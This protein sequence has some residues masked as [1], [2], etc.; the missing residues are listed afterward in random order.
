MR[1]ILNLTIQFF[2]GVVISTLEILISDFFYLQ[3]LRN[4]PSTE[5][6]KQTTKPKQ[7]NKTKTTQNKTSKTQTCFVQTEKHPDFQTSNTQ[8]RR[9]R[10]AEYSA[11]NNQSKFWKKFLYFE[12]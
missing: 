8:G 11:S 6:D 5:A 4:V 12:G 2:N 9:G 3:G 7:T 1:N 10:S